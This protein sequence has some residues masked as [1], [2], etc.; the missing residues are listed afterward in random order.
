MKYDGSVT[1]GE[2]QIDGIAPSE[3]CKKL[4]TAKL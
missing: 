3:E 4:R 1:A 2:Q